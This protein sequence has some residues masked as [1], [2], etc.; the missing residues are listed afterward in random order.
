VPHESKKG[1]DLEGNSMPT[2]TAQQIGD[3]IRARVTSSWNATAGDGLQAGH[4]ETPVTGIVTA[5]T[6]SID[7]LR[8]AVA[9]HAN[10]VVT[11]ECPFWSR[12]AEVRGY[13]G[14][15]Q[16]A[17]RAG[18]AH[19]P[20]FV[21]KQRYIDEQRLV[22]WRLASNWDARVATRPVGALARALSWEA[23]AREP[24]G[25]Y[26]VP[27]TTVA[28]LAADIQRR[29][30]VHGQRVVGAPDASVSRIALSRGFLLVPD[31]QK[32]LHAGDVDL[33]VAGEP[34]EWEAFPYVADLMAAG[35]VKGMILLGNAV[36]EE[37]E[38]GDVAT[39]LKT[40]VPELPVQFMPAGE[41]FTPFAR[42]AVK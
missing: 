42:S 16:T 31:V 19:D 30:L 41:P 17:T 18:M 7:V 11:R 6:P 26:V 37:P 39:W 9:A 23:F 27:K 34:V 21:F 32:T 8:R 29:L 5:W 15:S 38:L 3:R 36:S 10:F 35:R 12:E 28:A 33:F 20:T 13:S 2:L 14:A 25:R 22:I 1:F 4:P 40:L 24:A